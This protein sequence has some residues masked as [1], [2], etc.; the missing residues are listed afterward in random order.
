MFVSIIGTN[1]DLYDHPS[2]TVPMTNL[3]A[4]AIMINIFIILL[5]GVLGFW[6]FGVLGFWGFG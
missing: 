6:G 2:F 5:N 3:I 4:K 1:I